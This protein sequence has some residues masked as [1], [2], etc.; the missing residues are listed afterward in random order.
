MKNAELILPLS[1]KGQKLYDDIW[2]R[3]MAAGQ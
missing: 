2:A 3:F 1:A